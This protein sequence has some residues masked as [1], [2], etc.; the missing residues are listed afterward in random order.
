MLHDL[1]FAIRM[2]LKSPG[3]TAIAVATLTLGIGPNT[4]IFSVLDAV[5]V[6]PLPYKDPDR[7]VM[8]WEKLQ[9]GHNNV[10]AANFIDWK[11]QNQ[12]FEEMSA[13]IPGGESF[14]LSSLDPP[15]QVFP[16][17]FS[18]NYLDLLALDIARGRNLSSEE[19]RA[20]NDRVVILSHRFWKSRF[21]ADSDIVGK[22]LMLNG[23]K[24]T[25]VGVLAPH[26]TFDKRPSWL[27]TPLA[28]D[29]NL[30]NR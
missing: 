22:S 15:E 17:R 16:A 21:N 11:S 7:L 25:V 9:G 10:S 12:V 13:G 27:A 14:F 29:S 3:F 20:G 8:V 1:R 4:A 24:F 5:I 18:A 19:E 6:K 2:L 28:L 30:L 23:K 26:I